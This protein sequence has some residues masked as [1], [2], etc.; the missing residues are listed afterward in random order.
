MRDKGKDGDRE[1]AK[2][3]I[4]LACSKKHRA[5]TAKPPERKRGTSVNEDETSVR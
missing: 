1:P 3:S 4:Y 5:R 2:D